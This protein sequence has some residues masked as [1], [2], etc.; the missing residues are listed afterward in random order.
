MAL[1]TGRLIEANSEYELGRDAGAIERFAPDVG[2][3][4]SIGDALRA[5]R[6]YKGL[7]L[8]SI[9]EVTCIRRAYLAA[10]DEMRIDALPSRPFAIGYIRAY[11]K[12]LDLDGEAAVLRFKAQDHSDEAELREPVGVEPAQDHRI[13]LGLVTGLL[14]VGVIASWNFAQRA[15][16]SSSAE[17][18]VVA[19]IAQNGAALAEGPLSL[20][21]PL[22]PPVE[23]TVPAPYETPGL[24]IAAAAGGSADAVI[25]AKSA[26]RSSAEAADPVADLP[27][28][29]VP[30]GAV[31]GAPEQT[32]GLLIQA[33]KS[34]S[35]VVTGADGAIYFARQLAKGEAYRAPTIA[36]LS[37]EVSDP[38]A[39]QVFVGGESKGLLSANKT[40]LGNYLE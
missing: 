29:F 35:I 14:I 15:D 37:V 19:G 33:R 10:I 2:Y 23:S 18:P 13:K 22:P 38:E 28:T 30:A 1:D 17:V 12:A 11:A 40:K 24:A 34:A 6:E 32:P 8:E 31:F 26:E 20:G 39:F 16:D 9:S 3:G 21:A 5:T 36:G 7:S 27:S 4:C 25:A